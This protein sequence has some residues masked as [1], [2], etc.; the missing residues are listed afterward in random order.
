LD[1]VGNLS[2]IEGHAVPGVGDEAWFID[3]GRETG[4]RAYSLVWHQ[5]DRVGVV[6][7]QAP[8]SDTRITPAL[9]MLLARR[10]AARS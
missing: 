10:V 3:A 6:G 1:R 4:L 8:R 9:V 2:G 7:V 5:D